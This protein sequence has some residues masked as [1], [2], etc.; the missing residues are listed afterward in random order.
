MPIGFLKTGASSKVLNN[1][2]DVV[3]ANSGNFYEQHLT[4]LMVR[5]SAA[6]ERNESRLEEQDRREAIALEWKQLA[7]VCDR[8]KNFFIFL[9]K[10]CI[11]VLFSGMG[12]TCARFKKQ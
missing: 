5:V 7:L 10:K 4:E 1:E 6:V 2:S 11:F 8:S 3:G 12:S 9:G